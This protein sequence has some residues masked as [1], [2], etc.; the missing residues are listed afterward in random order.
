MQGRY[1]LPATMLPDAVLHAKAVLHGRGR[2]NRE[3]KMNEV[4]LEQQRRNYRERPAS[5]GLFEGFFLQHQPELTSQD[6]ARLQ[7]M[8]AK[9]GWVHLYL[10]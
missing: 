10:C 4:E 8:I 1:G 7:L 2:G 3:R 9:S 6:S 5:I